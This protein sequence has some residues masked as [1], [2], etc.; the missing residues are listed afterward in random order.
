MVNN[1]ILGEKAN[2]L[3]QLTEEINEYFI[4]LTAEFE[5]LPPTIPDVTLMVPDKFLVSESQCYWDLRAV[6]CRKSSGPDQIPNRLFKEFALW[7]LPKSWLP[8]CAIFTTCTS[9]IPLPL[10]QSIVYPIPKCTPPT[11]T[12]SDLRPISLTP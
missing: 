7:S 6:N 4:G 8:W 3:A 9:T 5:P 2:S 1:Q 10:K 12:Q 11:S